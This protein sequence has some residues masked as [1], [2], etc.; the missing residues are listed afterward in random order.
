MLNKKLVSMGLVLLVTGSMMVGC[1]TSEQ[2]INDAKNAVEENTLNLKVNHGTVLDTV[3]NDRVLI[4]KV[5]QNTGFNDG[6][7]SVKRWFSN[8]NKIVDQLDLTKYDE[9]QYWETVMLEDGTTTKQCSFTIKSDGLKQIKNDEVDWND[10]DAV[11]SLISDFWCMDELKDDV[12][13]LFKNKNQI[14]TYIE[15]D[16]DRNDNKV[17]EDKRTNNT[18]TNKTNKTKTQDRYIGSDKEAEKY[19]KEQKE[20]QPKTDRCHDCGVM[21]NNLVDCNGIVL[22]KSCIAQREA[23]AN[24]NKQFN[25]EQENNLED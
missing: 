13:K 23:K 6:E 18:K 21:S 17:T 1:S 14:S 11:Y 15:E 7:L 4:V 19:Y 3:V 12:G 24:M 16:T 5:Q 22:C 2:A 8:V 25:E 10:I 20:E 9:L